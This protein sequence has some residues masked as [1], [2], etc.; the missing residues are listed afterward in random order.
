[1]SNGLKMIIHNY[2]HVHP[3]AYI[4][5]GNTYYH[6]M[7]F[8]IAFKVNKFGNG[9]FKSFLSSMLAGNIY[10][11]NLMGKATFSDMSSGRSTNIELDILHL[12]SR[13]ARHLVPLPHTHGFLELKNHG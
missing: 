8:G 2:P 11:M 10:S 3:V 7:D 1:M 13:D 9:L 6:N 5:V 12:S 4:V